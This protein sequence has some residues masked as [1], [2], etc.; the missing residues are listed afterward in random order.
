MLVSLCL[1]VWGMT[2]SSAQDVTSN[3]SY[4]R[5]T[6]LDGLPQMQTERV[7]QDSRGYIWIGTLSGFARYDGEELT[8]FLNGRR[9]NIVSFTEVDGTVRAL[10]FRRQWFVNGDKAEMRQIDPEW[11]WLLN[12]FNTVDL[13]NG[14]V[15]LEDDQET[16]RRL[17]RV[18]KDRFVDILSDSLL[19]KMTPDRKLFMD[20]STIYLPTE[21]GLYVADNQQF[22]LLS[23]KPDVFTLHREGKTLYAL[24][25]DGIYTVNSSGLTQVLAY[26]FEAPDYG[27]SVCHDRRGH[28]VIADSHTL[29]IYI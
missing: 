6:T 24:A 4:R 28:L 23:L 22:R 19:D 8:T 9:E 13:P 17:C 10:N 2:M 27:L 3:L 5:F 21:D 25:A 16:H 12:N 20:G 11:H 18:E 29:Y 26:T 7:W 14:I 15:I 1:M